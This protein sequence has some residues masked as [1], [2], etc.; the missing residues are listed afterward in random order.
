MSNFINCLLKLT[1]NHLADATVIPGIV[2]SQISLR[3]VPD[4]DVEIISKSLCD[5]LLNNFQE[6]NSSNDLKVPFRLFR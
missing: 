6:L 5:F 1:Q 2:K 4:Q 3:I